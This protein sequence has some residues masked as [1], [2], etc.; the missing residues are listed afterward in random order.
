MFLILFRADFLSEFSDHRVQCSMLQGGARGQNLGHLIFLEWN[1]SVKTTGITFS[2]DFLSVTS[3]S[4]VH[5]P[6]G[7]LD[8]KI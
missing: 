8:V 3:D 7:R 5:R 6:R 1:H 2:I 4:R